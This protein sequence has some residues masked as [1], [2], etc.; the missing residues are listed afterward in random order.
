MPSLRPLYFAYGS[1]MSPRQMARRCPGARAIGR[2]SLAGWR[3]IINTRG[4]ANIVPS[5]QTPAAYVAGVLWRIDVAHIVLLDQWEGVADGIYRRLLVTVVLP[6]GGRRL[7]FTYVDARRWPGRPKP[8]YLEAA[9]LVGARAFALPE[10][11]V[12]AIEAF[13][14]ARPI[15]GA[16]RSY[17]GRRTRRRHKSKR[18]VNAVRRRSPL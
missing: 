3:F 11:H 9:V 12:A 13:K 18:L 15:G 1:N 14:P 16:R 10:A 5:R 8:A 7:A 6:C 17:H 2:A 4:A